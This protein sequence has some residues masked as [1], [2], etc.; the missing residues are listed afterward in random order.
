MR[1]AKLSAPMHSPD[2][3]QDATV[4]CASHIWLQLDQLPL[5]AKIGDKGL[6]GNAGSF[7]NLFSLSVAASTDAA[8]RTANGSKYGMHVN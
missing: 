1:L 4:R 3:V 7:I 6:L 2:Y 8:L 5:A